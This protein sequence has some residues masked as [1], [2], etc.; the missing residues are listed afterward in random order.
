MHAQFLQG[1]A[2]EH[3][4]DIKAH[5][6]KLKELVTKISKARREHPSL[7]KSLQGAYNILV[8]L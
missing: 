4:S 6:K 3:P 5:K 1:V 7:E 2:S 8:Q